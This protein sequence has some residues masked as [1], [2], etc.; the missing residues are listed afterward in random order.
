MVL[1][2]ELEETQAN[3]SSL[4][5]QPVAR[6]WNP[7]LQ[8]SLVVFVKASAIMSMPKRWENKA[9]ICYLFF[10]VNLLWSCVLW[11]GLINGCQERIKALVTSKKK[12]DLQRV[13][14]LQSLPSQKYCLPIPFLFHKN[15]E[16]ILATNKQGVSQPGKQR[17]TNHPRAGIPMFLQLCSK[18]GQLIRPNQNNRYKVFKKER[19]IKKTSGQYSTV[20]KYWVLT[21]FLDDLESPV[22]TAMHFLGRVSLKNALC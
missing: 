17:W 5:Y 2:K 8:D 3:Q 9:I 6:A 15:K 13:C 12:M 10:R 7:I 14:S 1:F 22:G 11:A 18:R 21:N 16:K 19:G 4:P 20:S